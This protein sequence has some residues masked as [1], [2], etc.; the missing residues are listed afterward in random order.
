MSFGS[1]TGRTR[2]GTK[3][4]SNKTKKQK[5]KKQEYHTHKRALLQET[6]PQ[7]PEQVRARTLLALDKLGHQVLSTEPGGYDLE[8]WTK[9]LNS[10][11]DD[12]EE[13][14]GEGNISGEFRA[15][16]R[17]ALSFLVP[18]A[19][20]AEIDA[21]VERLVK[22]EAAARAV[23]EEAETKTAARLAS[24][25][26]ERDKATKDLKSKREKLAEI[27]EARQSRQFFSRLFKSA[28]STE[29]AEASVR[30]LEARLRE[31][32]EEIDRSRKARAAGED[33]H[34]KDD[35][36]YQEAQ[37]RLE[38]ARASLLRMQ[39]AIRDRSQL[40]RER[41]TATQTIAA[42]ISSMKLQETPPR[43]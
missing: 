6:T 25:R 2:S 17:E 10:L 38:A 36:A 7:D 24:L 32:E 27:Q 33:D 23:M 21:E 34:G 39:S 1:E 28:P 14:I 30:Q 37:R 20:G 16:R 40:T 13:K 19:R 31:I 12:F 11:L 15:R 43:P 9:N 8:R 42:V 35:P 3:G 4:F 29:E 18:P 5:K 41:E 22:D 26:E